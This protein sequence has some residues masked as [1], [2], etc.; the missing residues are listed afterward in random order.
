MDELL[1]KW[2]AWKRLGVKASEM[3][4]A[5]LF[6]V[7]AT[8]RVRCGSVFHV[9]WNQEREAAGLDQKES[10]D[11]SAAIEVGVEAIKKLIQQDR[12]AKE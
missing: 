8:R 7:A 3:E 1:S 6:A 5:A 4:S 12:A 2:E 9:I 11:T 10:H